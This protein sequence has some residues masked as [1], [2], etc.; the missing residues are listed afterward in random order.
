MKSVLDI[1]EEFKVVLRTEEC[2]ELECFGAS[3]DDDGVRLYLNVEG[4][5]YVKGDIHQGGNEPVSG[6]G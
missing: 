4:T 5:W 2:N 1:A 3:L 6:E